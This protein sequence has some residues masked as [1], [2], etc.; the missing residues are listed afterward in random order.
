MLVFANKGKVSGDHLKNKMW[1]F[2][3]QSLNTFV[4]LF[5]WTQ[6]NKL[7]IVM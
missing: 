4:D 2:H 1:F 5:G 3:R 6:I 7:H